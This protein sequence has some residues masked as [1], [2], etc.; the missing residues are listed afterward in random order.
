MAIINASLIIASINIVLLLGILY[1]YSKNLL[2]IKSLF[3]AGLF[4][5]A[6]LFLIHNLLFV[7]F[8][9]TMMPYYADGLQMYTL[10]FNGLQMI[11]FAILNI[12]TWR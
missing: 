10:V 7:Y 9:I 12:I 5:F 3:T 1:I 8:A 11:A 6:S 4:I 2:K